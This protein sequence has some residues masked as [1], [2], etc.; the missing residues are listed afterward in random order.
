MVLNLEDIAQSTPE[1]LAGELEQQL[2]ELDLETLRLLQAAFL[3][4]NQA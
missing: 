3:D 4:S 1:V 2:E